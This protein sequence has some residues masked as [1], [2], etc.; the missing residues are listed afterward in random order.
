MKH[1]NIKATCYINWDWN[2]FQERWPDWG[3]ARIQMNDFILREFKKELADPVY[4][5][6][7]DEEATLKSLM[8]H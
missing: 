1:S 5:H 6:S 3:D 2:I 8:I 4:M 7:A